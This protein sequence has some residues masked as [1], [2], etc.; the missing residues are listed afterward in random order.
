MTSDGVRPPWH[1]EDPVCAEVGTEIFFAAD[2]DDFNT[3]GIPQDTYKEA[4]KIC[5]TCD[6]VVECA[7]W[8]IRNENHGVW[9][10]L[11]PAE[12]KRLR[13]RMGV[14]MRRTVQV[15]FRVKR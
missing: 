5:Q 12:R 9:G 1:F 4:R 10:G 14:G 8:G 11:S 15:P 6:H 2:A 13:G 7:E 3:V